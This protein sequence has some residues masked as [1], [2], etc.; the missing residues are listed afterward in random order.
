MTPASRAD[1]IMRHVFPATDPERGDPRAFVL[2]PDPFPDPFPRPF[3]RNYAHSRHWIGPHKLERECPAFERQSARWQESSFL[4]SPPPGKNWAVNECVQLAR[5]VVAPG[6]TGII[7]RLAVALEVLDDEQIPPEPQAPF[8]AQLD[9]FVLTRIGGG[10]GGAIRFHLRLEN[11]QND[12]QA[13]D[14]GQ[15]VTT[16]EH[17]PGLP[18]PELGSWSDSRYWYGFPERETRIRVPEARRAS[19]WVE[20]AI[21]PEVMPGLLRWYGLLA[22]HSWTYANNPAAYFDAQRGLF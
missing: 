2:A 12:D 21:D 18:H 10:R 7:H 5:F 13:P 8:W 3:P 4:A 11:F 20:M 16:A 22:G 1:R 6:C 15:I 17:L 9:P 19:L 14:L